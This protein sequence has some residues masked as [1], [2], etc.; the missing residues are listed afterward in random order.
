MGLIRDFF[1]FD[2][3][4]DQTES[5]I[6][7]DI[8]N[9]KQRLDD[10]GYS[11]G[12]IGNILYELQGMVETVQEK[13]TVSY[14][15]FFGVSSNIENI[16]S[17]SKERLKACKSIDNFI[18][19]N[20]EAANSIRIYGS[21]I[22]Y[23]SAAVHVGDY[24]TVVVSVDKEVDD[25]E[26]ESFIQSWESF[27]KI[28]RLMFL[29][30]KDVVS[31]GDGFLEKVRDKKGRIIKVVYIPSSTMIMRTNAQGD[32]LNYYQ[33]LDPEISSSDI[34]DTVKFPDLKQRKKVIEF[35]ENEIVHF[36]DGSLPG[37][38]DGPLSNLIVLWKFLKILEES[39]LIY[40]MTRA[41]RFIVYLLDV[42][43]KTREKIKASIQGFTNRLKAI[44]RLDVES[45]SIYSGKSTIP[46]SSDLVIPITK[47]SKTDVK[48]VASDPSSK[49]T[50]D[51]KLYTNRLT[52][53]LFI[54]HIFSDIDD[55]E[56]RKQIEKAFFR[57][58]R[59]YQKQ[60]TYALK[61]L[62]EE[63]LATAK[64]SGVD[65]EIVFPTVDTNEEIEIVDTIVRRMM[66]VNQLMAVLGIVPPTSW[67]VKYVLKDLT[68]LEMKELTRMLEE[69]QQQQQSG[70][71]YPDIF[72]ES[73]DR[74]EKLI[75]LSLLGGSLK[76][77]AVSEGTTSR[78]AEIFEIKNRAMLASIEKGIEYLKVV[79]GSK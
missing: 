25:T 66:V 14:D 35:E 75:L 15:D 64:F 5:V 65:I 27:T 20:P 23:G 45:G 74:D 49:D 26:V 18:Q 29:L 34:F 47:D 73:S 21:Y 39:L 41:R 36:N 68:Q 60:F 40:R 62:Y 44:F 1:N 58:V 76:D 50:G 51:L 4:K 17:Q 2:K 30:A 55:P 12:Q 33:I 13:A 31:F 69:E 28:K 79:K 24:K 32:I 71:E 78:A 8:D 11:E 72:T 43:G 67:I 70:E 61:D 56:Q 37:I 10:S 77:S 3:D 22:A 54:G 16:Y 6:K 9:F 57:V 42:T 46:A 52:N 53:N 63:V 19:Q 59:I 7:L 48:T 38:N